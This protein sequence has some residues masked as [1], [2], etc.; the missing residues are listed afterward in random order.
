MGA[1]I[2]GADLGIARYK[3]LVQVIMGEQ[4]GE[5]VRVGTRFFWDS[6]TDKFASETF[7]NVRTARRGEVQRGGRG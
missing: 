1:G 5:G 6:D 4:K 2:A 3:Y 7:V